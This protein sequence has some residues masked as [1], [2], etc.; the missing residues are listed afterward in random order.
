NIGFDSTVLLDFLISSETC[1]LEYF[2]RFLKLLQKDWNNFFT[3]CKYFDATESKCGIN[4]CNC[5]PSLIQ[6]RSAN[7]T[8]PHRL[9]ALDSHINASSWVSWASEPLNQVMM[10][11]KTHSIGA[12][13]LSSFHAS[14]SLVDYDSSDDS[15][16]ESTD[17]C[18]ANSKQT[19]L[20]Q[21]TVKKIQDTAGTSRDEKEL[22]LEPQSGSLVPKESNTPY[23]IDCE[24]TPHDNVSDVGI[25]YRVVKCLEELQ[26]AI[27][28]LQKK[29][30]FPYNPAALLK[31]LKHIEAIYNK[32]MNPL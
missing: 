30:L 17:Q 26:G 24:V 16:V 20:Q 15:E 23:S 8:T 25:F 28:R 21:E 29:N 6:D 4:I 5:V 31:L 13:S 1:F 32:S 3:I 10:S 19:S 2:V 27:Y 9:T 11:K 7:Q 12:H 14:Q 18:L 22:I